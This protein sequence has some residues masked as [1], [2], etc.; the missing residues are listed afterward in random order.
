MSIFGEFSLKNTDF[1]LRKYG[2]GIE[3][4]EEN[5]REAKEIQQ[6]F[7]S[8]L[9]R[10]SPESIDPFVRRT[11]RR[12]KLAYGQNISSPILDAARPGRSVPIR[13]TA[14]AAVPSTW[15]CPRNNA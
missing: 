9:A 3:F 6:G 7:E 2:G 15:G 14:S 8:M 10:F 5:S 4:Q 12:E 11:R 13:R 1:F